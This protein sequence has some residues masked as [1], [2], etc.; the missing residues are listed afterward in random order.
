MYRAPAFSIGHRI[1]KPP[2]KETDIYFVRR[3]QNYTRGVSMYIFPP[4]SSPPVPSPDEATERSKSC[5]IISEQ[6]QPSRIRTKANDEQTSY[7]VLK[8]RQN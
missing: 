8:A 1:E 3:A 2:S 7:T 5:I 4:S 6:E